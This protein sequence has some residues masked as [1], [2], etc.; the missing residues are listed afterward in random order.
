MSKTQRSRPQRR[1]R[2]LIDSERHVELGRFEA[3]QSDVAVE[4]DEGREFGTELF[5]VPPLRKSLRRHFV[6]DFFRGRSC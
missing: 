6:V 3:G 5:V 2:G 1:P 4:F